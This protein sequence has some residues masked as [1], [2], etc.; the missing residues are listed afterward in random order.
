MTHNTT[1]VNTSFLLDVIGILFI[2]NVAVLISFLS[3]YLQPEISIIDGKIT[4]VQMNVRQ[5]CLIKYSWFQNIFIL[6][7]NLLEVLE[8]N[9]YNTNRLKLGFPN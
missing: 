3:R 4:S 1:T 2:I 9:L 6:S 5:K 7:P 8:Y